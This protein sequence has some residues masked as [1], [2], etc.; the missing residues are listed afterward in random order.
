MALRLA[1]PPPPPYH[2]RRHALGELLRPDGS[3]DW[4]P[5]YLTDEEDM[6]QGGEQGQIIALLQASLN[7]W[8]REQ[9]WSPTTLIASDNFFAWVEGEPFVQ[10][11]PDIYVLDEP[12]YTADGKFPGRWEVWRPGQA[13]PRFAVE[14][15]SSNWKKDYAINPARYDH[16]G[17]HELVLADGDAVTRDLSARGR[18]PFAVYRRTADDRLE[19]AYRGPG[20]AYC[21]ELGAYLCFQADSALGGP[22]V[23]VSRDTEGKDIVATADEQNASLAASNAALAI[24][25]AAKDAAIESLA[26]DNATLAAEI[27]ALRARLRDSDK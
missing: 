7:A 3:I 9:R 17:V 18:Y 15:V 24:D 11:S 16:L 10:V 1:T 6:G 14:I 12:V 5:W 13:P 27:A 20:P 21:A 4:S 19:L 23:R 22:R 2:I 25:N 8:A 26:A